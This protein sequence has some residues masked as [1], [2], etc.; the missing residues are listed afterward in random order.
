MDD[1]DKIIQ[2]AAQTHQ[3][4]VTFVEETMQQISSKPVKSKRGLKLW[5]PVLVGGMAVVVVVFIAVPFKNHF[6]GSTDD[7]SRVTTSQ[8]T[9]NKSSTQ[10]A[11]SAGTDDTTLNS[12][13]SGISTAMNQETSDQDTA[14]GALNDSAEQ[15]TVPS[16]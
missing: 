6:S 2:N 8:S 3:A 13:L 15:I 4:S 7:T 5:L 16:E 11:A 14:N 12:D 9:T 10:P 1:F